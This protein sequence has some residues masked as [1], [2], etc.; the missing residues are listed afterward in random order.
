M[1]ANSKC[2]GI[3][4]FG[5]RVT[6]QIWTHNSPLATHSL[7]SSAS[8]LTARRAAYSSL[9]EKNFDD[10]VCPTVVPDHVIQS[11][12]SEN[13]WAPHPQTGVFWPPTENHNF[14]P[15]SSAAS[16]ANAS[17]TA[18]VLE[19]KVWFRQTSLEDLEKPHLLA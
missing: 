18:S 5:K 4:K 1:A 6:N 3:T 8:A 15:S 9:Y 7:L 10:R 11:V 12:H 19:E 16:A 17:T 14:Q 2:R 13:Y